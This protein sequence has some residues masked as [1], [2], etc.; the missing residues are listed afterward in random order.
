VVAASGL[1]LLGLG[2]LAAGAQTTRAAPPPASYSFEELAEMPQPAPGIPGMYFV[3]DFEIGG[4]NESGTGFW[5]SDISATNAPAPASTGEAVYLTPHAGAPVLVAA[6]GG[7]DPD[8]DVYWSAQND[9]FLG[10]VA[11][12]NSGDGAMMWK[13][14]P[15]PAPAD[16]RFHAGLYRYDHSSGEVSV[17]TKSG[18]PAPGGGTFAGFNFGVTINGRGDVLFHGITQTAAGTYTNPAD[19]LKYGVGIYMAD[20]QGNISA[21]VVPGDAAPS[22]GTFDNLRNAWINDRGDVTFGGHTSLDPA[23]TGLSCAES[24]YLLPK[25]GSLISVAHRNDVAPVGLAGTWTYNYAFGPRI[26]NQ[27]E[28]VF[29]G[30]VQLLPAVSC[31]TQRGVFLYKDGIVSAVVYPGQVFTANGDSYTAVRASNIVNNYFIN[32]G[33]EVVFVLQYNADANADSHNDSGVFTLSDGSYGVVA[34]SGDVIPGVGT[35]RHI[36]KPVINPTTN[37]SA[38]QGYSVNN[39]RGQV[40]FQATLNDGTGS[41]LLATP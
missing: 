39:N 21:V 30:C 4:M 29:I 22:G 34:K 35:I 25:N 23:C 9:S 32:D 18:S 38:P 26:N 36:E 10:P 11:V 19:S 20:L 40:I 24:I 5:G 17:I 27:G 2:L 16:G 1:S 14:A 28:V 12:N 33:G 41:L 7:T 3:R 6:S 13:L 31:G 8:G 15:S 37:T